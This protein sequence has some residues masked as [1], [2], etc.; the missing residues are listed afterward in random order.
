MKTQNITVC[1]FDQDISAEISPK[2]TPLATSHV[3]CLRQRKG[4][5]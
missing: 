2:N 3:K 4:L 1:Y 5:L